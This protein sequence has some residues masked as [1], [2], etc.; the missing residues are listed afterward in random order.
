MYICADCHNVS[1]VRE[2]QYKVIAQKR[3]VEYLNQGLISKGWEIVKEEALCTV[4][5]L[6]SPLSSGS[7][8]Q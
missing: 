7:L 4:C 5:Y 3:K 8:T 1:D 6:K 2:P